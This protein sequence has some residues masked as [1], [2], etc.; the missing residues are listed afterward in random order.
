MFVLGKSNDIVKFAISIKKTNKHTNYTFI[1]SVTYQK[2]KQFCPECGNPTL[3]RATVT[4][5]GSGQ[6]HYHITGRYRP[7]PRVCIFK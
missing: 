6:R 7:K 5:D 1:C 4:V 2:T 3:Q